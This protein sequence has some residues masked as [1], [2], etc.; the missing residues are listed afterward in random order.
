MS[1][2]FSQAIGR[3][4]SLDSILPGRRTVVLGIALILLQ[5]AD[6]LFTS[7]GVFRFGTSV[8]GNPLLRFF[9]EEF[10]CYSTLAA[11]K[12]VAIVMVLILCMSAKKFPWVN[13]AMG[14]ITCVYTFAAIV[15]WTYVLFLEPQLK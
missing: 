14:A 8:E 11:V 9:M 7:V 5:L 13:S 3:G 1:R 12:G 10:G 15:P 2:V 4:D 6:G